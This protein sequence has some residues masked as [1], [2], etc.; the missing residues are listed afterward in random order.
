MQ[1]TGFSTN[2]TLNIGGKLV[3]LRQPKI[4]G[5]L[6]VTPDS[7][8]DGARYKTDEEII[9]QAEKMLTEGATFIDVGGYSSRPGAKE[10]SLTDELN[11]SIHAIRLILKEFPEAII[12]IDTF[13]SDVAKA[14][15]QEGAL[16]VNDIS[17]GNLDDNMIET[18]ARLRIPYIAMHMKGNPR[19]MSEQ[20]TYEN[21]LRE[22]AFYFQ[23]KIQHFHEAG[24]RDVI[25]DPGF[26]FAKTRE[27][28]FELLQ[29][30]DYFRMLSKPLLVGLSRKS[31][32]WKTLN[33]TPAEALNG[34]AALN[35]LA[36]LK[37]ADILRVHDV[38]EAIQIT[39]LLEKLPGSNGH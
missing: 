21:L 12:S 32:I 8:Y 14:A 4:M 27:Q 1:N 22:M 2:K 33:I 29:H 24:I 34:T 31:M 36:L 35:T 7:F 26:G 15:V 20:T 19:T 18:V 5:I 39:T 13:R 10:V 11:R 16:L 30:L 28:N 37:G 25:L 6:N 23:E 9:N 3:D 17:A 38:K